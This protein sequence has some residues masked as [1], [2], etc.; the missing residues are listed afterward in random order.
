MINDCNCCFIVYL[1]VV[2]VLFFW[3]IF[4]KKVMVDFKIVSVVEFI[5]MSDI[6]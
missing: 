6:F 1:V 3:N 2:K 5:E 4:C